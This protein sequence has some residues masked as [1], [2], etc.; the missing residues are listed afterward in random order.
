MKKLFAFMLCAT[1]LC[2]CDPDPDPEPVIDYVNLLVGQ[3]VYDHPEEGVWETIKFTSSGMFYYSNSNEILYEFENEN[4]NGRY[5]VDGNKVTGT[6]KL[7]EVTQMNLDMQITAINDL[8][9]TAKFNDT[10]LTFTYARLLDS[11]TIEYNGTILP[12]YDNLLRG[13]DIIAYSS[14]NPN[15]AKVDAASGRVTGLSSGRTYID[16]ITSEGTAVVEI[17]VKGLLLYNF[18]EFIGAEKSVIYKTFGAQP[19]VEDENVMVYQ[20][21]SDEIKFLRIGFNSWTGKVSDIRLYLS[22]VESDDVKSI[23]KYFSSLYTVYEKGTTDTYKAYINNENFDD[24]SVG[25][26]WDIPNLEI[27][28]VALNHDLFTDY[29]PFL[30]KTQKE[31][32]SM[33]KDS[34]PFKEDKNQLVYGISDG[35]V[36]LV[37]CYYTFDFVHTYNNAQAVITQLNSNLNSNDVQSYLAKKYIFLENE[38][39]ISEKVY[40][41]KDGLIAVF[42][43]IDY[44]QV[45]YYSN[46]SG[47]RSIESFRKFRVHAF[48]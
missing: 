25:I 34:Q 19:A 24:A 23:T 37:C 22:N 2:A 18:D 38:S 33:M 17:I 9:F 28:Y 7:N 42:Y 35:K 14:H 40:L 20:N 1:A 44:G 11:E 43:N 5:F 41:T 31:V 16:V 32:K 46:V 21:V 45:S 39:T 13:A 36:D 26:T 12:N 47:S 3:W 48:N 30:G 8:E 10:G 15:I 27:T 6:Y 4:V 29:S